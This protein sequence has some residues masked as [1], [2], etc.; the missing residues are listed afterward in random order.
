[1]NK[2]ESINKLTEFNS[3]INDYFNGNYKNEQE[4]KS[5][6]NKLIPIAQ[7]LVIKSNSLK[8]MTMAPP[9][10]IGGMVIKNFNPFDMLFTSFWGISIIPDVSDMIEQSIGKYENGLVS[11]TKVATEKE[12][13][14]YTN[15]ITLKW[16]WDNVPIKFWI[17]S[18][19][20][21]IAVFL[22]GYQASN[23]LKENNINQKVLKNSK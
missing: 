2:Q 15:K 4:L 13:I 7:E 3:L 12:P 18:I 10:A 17:G 14:E 8:L 21:L 9:P 22:L 5:K 23:F 6:I 1:M 20:I 16:L 19:S 11:F